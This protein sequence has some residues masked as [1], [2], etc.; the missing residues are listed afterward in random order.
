MARTVEI[1]YPICCGM[2]VHKSFIVACIAVTDERSHTEH[3]IKRFSTFTGDLRRLADWLASFNCRDVCMES[4]GKYWIPI[5]NA[6]EKTCN[7]CLTHPKYVKAIK[8]KKT[9]KKDAKWIS[10]LF[11]CDLVRSSFIP[12]PDIRQ[13]RDLCRYYVKLT[14]FV[15]SEKNRAQNCLTMCNFKLDD[16]FSDVFGKSATRVLDA[17]LEHGNGNFELDGLISGKC[18]ASPGE[19]RAA[20]DGELNPMQ[21]EKLALIRRHMN[22]INKLKGSLESLIYDLAAKYQPQ[23]DLLMTVPGISTKLTAI[24]ILAEIGADMSVFETAK[25]LVSWA[26]LT[27]QNQESAGKTKTTRI[28][29]AGAY[30]KPLLVQIA[31]ACGKSDKCPELK[32]KFLALKNRRGGKKAV[33]AIARKLLTAMWHILS[34]N[35][36]YNAELYRRADKPPVARELTTAQAVAYLR[37]K[38]FLIVDEETGEIA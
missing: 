11:K 25:Q 16:V 34:K 26:G 22:D 19:I 6:L 2:D 33:I 38:G 10:E 9:D 36:A 30:L 7:V 4:S 28:G 20:L 1:V 5:F 12:P 24:R 18:K 8:G 13:L 17:L 29:R 21:S 35:E 15:S 31:L 14:G 23:I 27:P 32:N 3:H 37:T